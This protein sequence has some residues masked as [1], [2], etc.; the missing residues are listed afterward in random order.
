[1]SDVRPSSTGKRQEGDQ[2]KWRVFIVDDHPMLRQGIRAVIDQQ[3]D[4]IVCGEAASAPEAM[5]RIEQLRPDIVVAD[6][7]LKNSSGLELIKDLVVRCPKIPALM[8]SMHDESFYAERALHAGAKGFIAKEE[9]T[10]K[11]IE[12]IRQ[13]IAGN[14]YFSPSVTAR[15]LSRS[16]GGSQRAPEGSPRSLTDRELQILELIGSGYASGEVAQRLHLSVK[17]I[18]SHRENIKQKLGLTSAS[19]LVKYAYN[20]MQHGRT[21]GPPSPPAPGSTT[22]IDR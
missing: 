11:V 4:M 16:V 7:T 20:W 5:E 18:E 13:V 2:A 17:T 6:L 8:L 1:M 22:N 15:I 19:Q 12:G 14:P 3:R 9:G 10:E 21:S